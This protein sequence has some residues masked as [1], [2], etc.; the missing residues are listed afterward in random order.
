LPEHPWLVDDTGGLAAFA[1]RES[2]CRE[3]ELIELGSMPASPRAPERGR[4]CPATE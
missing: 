2:G 3:R 1:L 4:V